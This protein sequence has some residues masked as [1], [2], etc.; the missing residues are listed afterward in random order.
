MTAKTGQMNRSS[1][2]DGLPGGMVRMGDEETIA[3]RGSQKSARTIS[4]ESAFGEI[5]RRERH[6][7]KT[8]L[9]SVIKNT[10]ADASASLSTGAQFCWSISTTLTQ[11]RRF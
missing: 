6:L 4:R 10:W 1:R 2:L 9:A 11:G 8:P 3:S 5:V 7:V